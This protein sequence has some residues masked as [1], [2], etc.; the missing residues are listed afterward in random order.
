[1]RNM[2]WL[3]L[4][5]LKVIKT[6][7]GKRLAV[8]CKAQRVLHTHPLRSR[9]GQSCDYIALQRG[10]FHLESPSA[11]VLILL[12][13]RMRYTSGENREQE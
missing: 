4:K 2:S 1:M 7:L 6:K 11:D 9:P 10:T 12:P 8:L 13:D 3:C 5:D